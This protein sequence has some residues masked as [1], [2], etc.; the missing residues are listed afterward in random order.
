MSA[1][2]RLGSSLY[3]SKEVRTRPRQVTALRQPLA[4]LPN[5]HVCAEREAVG[6]KHLYFSRIAP[7]IAGHVERDR[8]APHDRAQVANRLRRRF[9]RVRMHTRSQVPAQ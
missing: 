1:V 8:T 3:P 6:R 4:I 5:A 2:A 9:P 7:E